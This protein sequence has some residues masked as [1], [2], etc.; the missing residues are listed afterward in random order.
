MKTSQGFAALPRVL[1][2]S[3]VRAV[4]R[5][6]DSAPIA[7]PRHRRAAI[8]ALPNPASAPARD[9]VPDGQ[10]RTREAGA[11]KPDRL[12]VG[13]LVLIMVMLVGYIATTVF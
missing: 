2:L 11:T 10:T 12:E 3:D 6:R 4:L 9:T 5:R 7:R 8:V 1:Y 13:I